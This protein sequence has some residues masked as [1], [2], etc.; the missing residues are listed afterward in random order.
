[1]SGVSCQML[2]LAMLDTSLSQMSLN[3]RKESCCL[4]RL[5]LRLLKAEGSSVLQQL[6]TGDPSPAISL[7]HYRKQRFLS[8][9]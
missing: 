6:F 1:M 7:L 4:E 9:A 8:P 2:R 3:P 5:K